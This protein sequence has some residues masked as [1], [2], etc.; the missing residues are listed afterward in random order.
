ML[1]WGAV[2][3]PRLRVTYEGNAAKLT[4]DEVMSISESELAT[5]GR[6]D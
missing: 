1:F 6:I 4:M 2:P 5:S 3:L